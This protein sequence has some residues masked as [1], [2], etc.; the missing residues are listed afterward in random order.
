MNKIITFIKAEYAKIKDKPA[1]ERWEYLWDY[2]KIP[3][4]CVVLA[5][6]LLAQGIVSVAN[7]TETVF[8]AYILNSKLGVNDEMFLNG[9]YEYAGIDSSSQSAAFYTDMTVVEGKTQNNTDIFQRI[10]AGISIRDTDFITGS[11]EAFHMCAYNTGSILVDLREFL[12][13]Q[14]LEK[15]ADR[16]YYIDSAVLEQMKV[17]LG[18][19]I[20]PGLIT[21]PDPKKPETMKDPIPVGIDITD[22]KAFQEAYYFS[23]T[24]IYIGVVP[25]TQRPEL[26]AKFIDYLFA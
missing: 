1:K 12:A 19:H 3:A 24:T 21:Y 18:E 17:P 9:F 20:E 15:L 6:V 22:C 16:L 10:M 13:P 25:N 23:G 26:T 2:Y 7:R 8:S 11:P 14:T 4:L 5:V